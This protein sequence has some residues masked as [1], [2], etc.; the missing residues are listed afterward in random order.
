MSIFIWTMV[1]IE[2]SSRNNL[3]Y[4]VSQVLRE[5]TKSFL[6]FEADPDLN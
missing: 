4:I 2:I 6:L 3:Q 1:C 5:M